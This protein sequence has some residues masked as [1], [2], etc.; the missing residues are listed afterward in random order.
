MR[1]ENADYFS[2]VQGGVPAPYRPFRP[3]LGPAR[4]PRV[5]FLIVTGRIDLGSWAVGS[6]CGRRV[7]RSAG[8]GRLDVGSRCDELPHAR[9][10]PVLARNVQRSDAGAAGDA[11][12]GVGPK[13]RNALIKLFGSVQRIRAASTQDIA[14]VPGFSLHLAEDIKRHLGNGGG[15]SL[16]TD[17]G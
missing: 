7:L 2:G 13:R 3:P 8:P 16:T 9:L 10:G 12:H 15:E 11:M 5:L 6:V 14:D 1:I 4:G 17:H